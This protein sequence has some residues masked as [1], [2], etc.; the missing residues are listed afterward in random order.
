MTRREH[1][2]FYLVILIQKDRTQEERLTLV[3]VARVVEVLLTELELV[4]LVEA[5]F[6][7]PK[8]ESFRTVGSLNT[9]CLNAKSLYVLLSMKSPLHVTKYDQSA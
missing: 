9:F 4:V 5:P 2:S 8:S 3:V 7:L 1:V 6:Q